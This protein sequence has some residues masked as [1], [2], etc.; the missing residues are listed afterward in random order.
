MN[1]DPQKPFGECFG[2]NKAYPGAKY[3]QGIYIYDSHR[4]CMNASTS[5]PEKVKSTVADATDKL[6]EKA[7]AAATNAM[8]RLQVAKA[9]NEEKGTPASKAAYTKAVNAYNKAQEK[10]D[11]LAE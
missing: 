8:K 10:L 7:A 9:T 5:A 2:A 11:N 3:T 4:K 6:R 1:F